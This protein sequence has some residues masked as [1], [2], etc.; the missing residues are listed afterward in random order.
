MGIATRLIVRP[1]H[2]TIIISSRP[3]VGSFSTHY[4][5]IVHC[6][7][8]AFFSFTLL[9]PLHPRINHTTFESSFFPAFLTSPRLVEYCVTGLALLIRTPIATSDSFDSESCNR[10]R[11]E[12][13]RRIPAVRRATTRT[14]SVGN[15]EG[16]IVRQ[17]SDFVIC[18][19]SSTLRLRILLLPLSPRQRQ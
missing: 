5:I 15:F 9:P 14:D 13:F 12:P 16:G 6:H 8:P 4:T 18:F 2:S 19:H 7:S 17:E 10:I 11:V 3:H 1:P